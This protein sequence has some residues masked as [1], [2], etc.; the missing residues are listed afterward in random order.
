[1]YVRRQASCIGF[2]EA[3]LAVEV[4]QLEAA[5]V[6]VKVDNGARGDAVMRHWVA[7]RLMISTSLSPPP[8]LE[9]C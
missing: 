1:M 3:T 6:Q 7:S 4:N 2:V 5:W 9:F 8:Y